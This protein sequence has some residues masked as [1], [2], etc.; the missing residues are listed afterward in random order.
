MNIF[1]LRL[2]FRAHPIDYTHTHT[3][4]YTYI[5][6]SDPPS[7]AIIIKLLQKGGRVGGI[8]ERGLNDDE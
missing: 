5:K 3:Y 2:L 8:F 4:V 7:K 1:S 6:S